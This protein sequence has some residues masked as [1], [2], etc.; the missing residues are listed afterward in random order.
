VG[1]L[2]GINVGYL[3]GLEVSSQGSQSIVMIVNSS[4]ATL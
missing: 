1:L 2:E 4:D 3:V